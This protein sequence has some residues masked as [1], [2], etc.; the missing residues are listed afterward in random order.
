M[1]ADESCVGEE[2]GDDDRE[3]V[4]FT[5]VLIRVRGQGRYSC[6]KGLV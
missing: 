2:D 5:V 1:S 4:A 6:K 3:M